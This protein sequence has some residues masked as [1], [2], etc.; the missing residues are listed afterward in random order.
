MATSEKRKHALRWFC[1]M[2]LLAAACEGGGPTSYVL[3]YGS[4]ETRALATS[5]LSWDAVP[6][7]TGYRVVVSLDRAGWSPV[8][9]TALAAETR[10]SSDKL[11]WREGHPLA[12]R[13][14]FWAMRAYD[15]QGLLL[16][17]SEGR[18]IRFGPPQGGLELGITFP[19]PSP[20]PTQTPTAPPGGATP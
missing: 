11:A 1:A 9:V 19:T 20:S 18:E 12:D 16:T 7:A 13:S 6:G 14:Y 10:V 2:A 8:A 4:P 15:A 17:G 3:G 5:E